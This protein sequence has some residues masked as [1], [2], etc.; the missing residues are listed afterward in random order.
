[1]RSKY[2]LFTAACTLVA[3]ALAVPAVLAQS[4]STA[5]APPAEHFFANPRFARPALSPDG[6]MLAVIVGNPGKRDA[7]AVI[8][9]ATNMV[10]PTAS[11]SDADI[12]SFQWVN[13]Q[14]LVFNT[15][16]RKVAQ[17]EYVN[18]PGLYA[19]NA[20][21]SALR[22]L[23]QR[24][25]RVIR[26]VLPG[27]GPRSSG[28]D[29]SAGRQAVSPD[30]MAGSDPLL[31]RQG[32]GLLPANTSLAPRP[33]PQD[34]SSVYVYSPEFL[35][36]EVTEVHLILLDTL[37]GS[38]TKVSDP[39]RPRGWLFDHQGKPRLTIS[40]AEQ[41][42]V[43]HLRGPGDRWKQIASF[44]AF[45]GSAGAFAP[46]GFSAD[47]KLYVSSTRGKDKSAVYL[48]DPDSGTMGTAPLI[49][50][51]GFDFNGDLITDS[52]HVL[53]FR[54]TTDA[55]GTHWL[56]ARMKVLQEEV[57]RQLPD[58]VNLLTPPTRAQSPW[59]LVESFSDTQPET[60]LLF[61]TQTKAFNR[62]GSSHPAIK[63][64]H[65]GRQEVVGY[66]ARDGMHI[67]A[68]LTMPAGSA[69]TGLPL[70]VLVHGGPFARGHTSGWQPVA[71]F[72]ASR[73][74]AVLEPSF[75]GTTG[76]GQRHWR[77]GWRQWG[78]AMQDD[79]ADGARWAVK[80]GLAD[81]K[82]ICIAGASYGGYAALMGLVKDPDL[83]KC[84]VNSAG[85]TDIALLY[86]QHWDLEGNAF[87]RFHKHG[88]PYLIGDLVK[89]ADQFKAT[90]PLAQA[91]RIKQPLLMAYGSDDRRVPL[92]HGKAFHDAVKRTNADVEMVVYEHEGHSLA[93]PEN[94]VDF[95]KRVEK[96]LD[97][98]IGTPSQ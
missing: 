94:R 74:Y 14:R 90:S 86:N 66:T 47:G 16:D 78:L 75:R 72:L 29:P 92:V 39:G 7:L 59:I 18:G 30:A 20:D 12:R 2:S 17:G 23:A 41:N 80:Q 24:R 13:N 8:D 5:T 98:H 21:G 32:K 9:L 48:Y 10:H 11:F 85:V 22:Q 91:A 89:D 63:R 35:D 62:V 52:Q 53:G 42:Q 68:L 96:F 73:G 79:L 69:R 57:D 26:G 65:M 31:I 82:R 87:D 93:L 3:G 88:R 46:L 33:G 19:A 25:D 64:E 15:I 37:T 27:L 50:A 49:Q 1:M 45:I 6:K 58:T 71:Q 38:F 67:P 60:F 83:F 95:Y 28:V 81:G 43:I 36:G 61:N 44:N 34:S 51:D 70:V 84:A 56:D 97:R 4:V 76:F 55:P 40:A 77:A 54:Y